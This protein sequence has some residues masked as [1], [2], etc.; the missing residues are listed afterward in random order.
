MVLIRRPGVLGLLV[1][2]GCSQSLFDAHDVDIERAACGA[3]CVADAAADF[4]G[5][6]GGANKVWQWRYLDDHRDKTW[7]AMSPG[8]DPDALTGAMGNGIT[9]CTTHL[10]EPACQALPHALLV[11]VGGDSMIDPAIEL[12]APTNTVLQLSVHAFVPGGDAAQTIR[13]YRNSREDV[14]FTGTATPGVGFQQTI[15][16]D[17]V[18]GD[19]FLVA[20]QP[21]GKGA[22]N[23]GLHVFANDTGAHFP[24]S[25]QRYV[26]F[27]SANMNA[28]M[29]YSDTD[30]L[31]GSTTFT[32]YRYPTG[33]PEPTAF[34]SP[35][36]PFQEL[37][38]AASVPKD[39]FFSEDQVLDWS[40][41][42]TVQLWVK[43]TNGVTL[44]QPAWLF[45]DLDP[46][47]CGGI[48]ITIAPVGPGMGSLDVKACT[49]PTPSKVKFG[50]TLPSYPI[51]SAWRFVRV[52]RTGDQVLVCVDGVRR[53]AL[54]IKPDRP[55][56]F[57]TTNPPHLGKDHVAGI[58][59]FFD[60]EIDDL[61]VITGALPCE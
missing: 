46:V 2:V 43:L 31:C 15:T 49:D 25:C 54:T 33:T 37:R 3:M 11:S 51:D 35:P 53:A 17:A 9:T 45:S 30:D 14:L 4:N 27:T 16:L 21:T 6:V 59:S 10:D 7:M 44:M 36:G 29:T 20:I 50:T 48:D 13:L 40:N 28:N 39:Y 60:G 26:P 8:P 5:M 61:R 18:A 56:G 38:P 55:V 22:A 32:F 41:D 57:T 58:G 23:V 52:V 47:F 19:R 34:Q 12:T 42:V 24:S 1:L